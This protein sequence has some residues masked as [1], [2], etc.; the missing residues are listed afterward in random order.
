ML[1]SFKIIYKSKTKKSVSIFSEKMN[2]Y[3]NVILNQKLKYK[4]SDYNIE[5]C[6]SC[7]A[8]HVHLALNWPLTSFDHE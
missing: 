1:L 5:M 2:K 4:L 3:F 8:K 7:R 6:I